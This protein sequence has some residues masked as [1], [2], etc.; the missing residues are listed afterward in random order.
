MKFEK[1]K[2]IYNI[3]IYLTFFSIFLTNILSIK[4]IK[5]GKFGTFLYF[6]SYIFFIILAFKSLIFIAKNIFPKQIREPS[7]T[8]FPRNLLSNRLI[9]TPLVII[10]WFIIILTNISGEEHLSGE[11]IIEINTMMHHFEV[12]DDFGFNQTVLFGYPARQYFLPALP[13]LIFGRSVTSLHSGGMLYFLIGLLI[14]S[15]GVLITY[16]DKRTGDL[17]CGIILSMIFHIY[18]V[19]HFLFKAEQ[20]IFPFSFTLILCG[21][22]LH[23]FKS[24]SEE[25]LLLTGFT[26]LYLI[27]SYTP[28]LA[29]FFLAISVLIYIY[30]KNITPSSGKIL[31]I[32]IIAFTLVSFLLSLQFRSDIKIFDKKNPLTALEMKN[33]VYEA[34]S[35]LIYPQKNPP[36]VSKFFNPIFLFLLFSPLFF[37]YGKETAFLSWW[38]VGTIIM[39]VLSRGYTWYGI[40]FTLHKATIIFPIIFLILIKILQPVQKKLKKFHILL[41]IIFIFLFITG[42]IYQRSFLLSEANKNADQIRSWN[43]MTYIKEVILKEKEGDISGDIILYLDEESSK[44]YFTL[45]HTLKYFAPEMKS[46]IMDSTCSLILYREHYGEAYLLISKNALD[47]NNKYNKIKKALKYKGSFSFRND[48]LLDIYEIKQIFP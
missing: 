19:N 16:E 24:K 17:I 26:L 10:I 4:Y 46:Y 41:F 2:N 7:N 39:A 5:T 37:L 18:F 12:S 35:Q 21:L 36:A 48:E 14:F 22:F 9:I 3:I 34:F 32:L 43:L 47:S 28:S 6:F 23:Y 38:A 33:K 40:A 15:T 42:I 20:S 31:I 1:V 8:D 11:T 27:F 44:K 45:K 29:V 30:I 13:S 25:I